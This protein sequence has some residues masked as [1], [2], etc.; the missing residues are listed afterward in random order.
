VAVRLWNIYVTNVDGC[1]GLKLLHLLTDELKVYSTIDKPTEASFENL[2]LCL[3][4]YFASAVSL[5]DK[6]AQAILGQDNVL[7]YSASRLVWNRLS[8][9]E[10]FWMVRL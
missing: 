9:R 1:A 5:D 10:I 8:L 4:I 2:A 7:I 6:E 3:A